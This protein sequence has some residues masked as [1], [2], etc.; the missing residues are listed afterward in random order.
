[1]TQYKE[2]IPLDLKRFFI[3]IALIL[4]F[5]Y[6]IFRNINLEKLKNAIFHFNPWYLIPALVVYF[7]G[8]W[9]RTFRWQVLLSPIKKCKLSNLFRF[10]LIGF[11]INNLLPARI[12][13]IYRAHLVGK[14]EKI[15]RS[16]VIAT[17]I[18][19]RLFDGT[20]LL[21]IMLTA[22]LFRHPNPHPHSSIINIS[23]IAQGAAIFFGCGLLIMFLILSFRNTSVSIIR[24]L[25]R[26]TPK[27]YHLLLEK[28]THKFLDGLNILKNFKEILIVF[29][30]SLIAWTLEF[31]TY[32]IIALGFHLAPWPLHY[33]S[34]ALLMAV[35]ILSMLIPGTPGGVGIFELIGINFL[36]LYPISKEMAIAY[37]FI[38]HL[39]VLVPVT[40]IGL[41]FIFHEGMNFQSNKAI[42]LEEKLK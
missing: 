31:T 39:A 22:I 2:K 35:T 17:I 32:Y 15:S 10:L 7:I 27:K 34:V 16:S 23:S 18:I 24:S 30:T 28:I 41:F 36:R 21:F 8:Y 33:N 40:V 38:T 20:A 37:V 4:L 9:V 11:T 6:F 14:H 5:F 19:E 13:E 12:G 29:F 1:M 42:Q 26:H 25:I 3:G